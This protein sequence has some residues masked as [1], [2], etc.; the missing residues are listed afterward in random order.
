MIL[1]PFLSEKVE[2]C[3]QMYGLGS[4]IDDLVE[5]LHDQGLSVDDVSSVIAATLGNEF[6]EARLLV[7]GNPVWIEVVDQSSPII[8][9]VIQVLDRDGELDDLGDG[10]IVFREPVVL[11][12]APQTA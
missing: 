3:R 2:E 1:T 4:T 6:A 11:V 8:N 5:I 9:E 10:T 12:V 7:V